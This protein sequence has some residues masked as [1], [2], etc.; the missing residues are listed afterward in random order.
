V[1]TFVI[2]GVSGGVIETRGKVYKL[3]VVMRRKVNG[4]WVNSIVPLTTFDSTIADIMG[5]SEASG[6]VV[7]TG[8]LTGREWQGKHYL[9]AVA[10][11]VYWQQPEEKQ[12]EQPAKGN[13]D[14]IPF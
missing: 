10:D 6:N 8:R 13:L 11:S 3:A 4:E 1:N 7:L 5:Q 2:R 14:D 12:A 9:D